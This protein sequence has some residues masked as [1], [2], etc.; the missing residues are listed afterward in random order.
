MAFLLCGR[1]NSIITPLNI[2]NDRIV[3]MQL[4]LST[5]NYLFIFQMYL[6]CVNHSYEKYCDYI[7]VL[8]DLYNMYSDQGLVVFMGDFNARIKADVF[9]YRDNVLRSFMVDCNLCA[10]NT[11]DICQ[12]PTNSYVSYDD[13]YTSLIDYI[14]IPCDNIDFVTNCEIADDNCLNVSRHRPI[15]CCLNIVIPPVETV[16]I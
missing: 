4:Q 5:S 15:F 13:M 7:N 12:G 16:A 3:G 2:D 1:L 10:V 14:C 6:P 11:L 9:S 8:Y